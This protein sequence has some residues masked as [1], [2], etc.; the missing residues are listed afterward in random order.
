MH[1]TVPGPIPQ[2][3]RMA[4]VRQT[5]RD[6]SY[7]EGVWALVAWALSFRAYPLCGTLEAVFRGAEV[8]F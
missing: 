8:V 7:W 2:L 5:T 1:D 4:F 6:E 3:P